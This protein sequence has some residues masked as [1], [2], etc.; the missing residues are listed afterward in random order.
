[1]NA[2][3]AGVSAACAGSPDSTFAHSD[4][5]ERWEGATN[6]QP[7]TL[8][9]ELSTSWCARRRPLRTARTLH[10][11]VACGPS[12]PF[13]RCP[14]RSPACTLGAYGGKRTIIAF[15]S[16]LGGDDS[17]NLGEVVISE[18][19]NHVLTVINAGRAERRRIDRVVDGGAAPPSSSVN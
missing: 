5:A 13:P 10:S 4:G 12:R 2:R 18:S 11:G 8:T 7:V 6:C 1:M 3:D 14:M 17:I 9:C 16:S 15:E 19:A